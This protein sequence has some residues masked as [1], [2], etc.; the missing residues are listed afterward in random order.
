MSADG[1]LPETL[2]VAPQNLE[3]EQGLLGAILFDNETFNRLGD[4]LKP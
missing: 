1:S 3:A 4:R 2:R